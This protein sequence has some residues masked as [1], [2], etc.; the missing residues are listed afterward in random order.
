MGI[1]ADPISG[2]ERVATEVKRLCS[3]LERVEGRL[4]GGALS[5]RVDVR[6]LVGFG[7]QGGNLL[8]VAN[9]RD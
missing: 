2:Y 5:Q 3:A 1:D 4:E 6:S 9:N 7:A 8:L